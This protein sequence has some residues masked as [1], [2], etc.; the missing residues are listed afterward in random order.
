MSEN[1]TIYA[2]HRTASASALP[3]QIVSPLTL[4]EIDEINLIRRWRQAKEQG[5]RMLLDGD[6]KEAQM[7]G[8]VEKLH[9]KT[10]Y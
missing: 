6:T 2:T 5:L 8:R 10:A 4:T 7:L 1:Q 3:V 9:H